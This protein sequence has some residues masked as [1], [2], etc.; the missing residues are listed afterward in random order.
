[1]LS[2]RSSPQRHLSDRPPGNPH[3]TNTGCPHGPVPRV[4]IDFQAP[5]KAA[6]AQ[7]QSSLRT[8]LAGT[9]RRSRHVQPPC[10]NTFGSGHGHT[11][12][13]LAAALPRTA[14]RLST[15]VG[16]FGGSFSW[17]PTQSRARAAA[18]PL[19]TRL[20]GTAWRG[21][22]VRPPCPKHLRV[23]AQTQPPVHGVPRSV[24]TRRW[25]LDSAPLGDWPRVTQ[26]GASRR[27]TRRRFGVP[28]GV[29]PR[30]RLWRPSASPPL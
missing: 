12:P 13:P 16:P 9:A 2:G 10:L 14:R 27:G 26:R 19:R 11:Q 21:R 25:R 22:R 4:S 30:P 29:V 17:A 28:L 8:R 6:R 23:G 15:G 1:M 5:T 24:T 7:L 20:A 3:R 18:E